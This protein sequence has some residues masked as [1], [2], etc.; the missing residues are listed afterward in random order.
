MCLRTRPK[1]VSAFIKD[2]FRFFLNLIVINWGYTY[3]KGDFIMNKYILLVATFLSGL[4]WAQTQPQ[5][6]RAAAV[7][8]R[9]NQYPKAPL[10][11][12]GYLAQN[13]NKC[14][15][16]VASQI[17]TL[18]EKNNKT[19]A[20]YNKAIGAQLVKMDGRC[21]YFRFELIDYTEDMSNGSYTSD[22]R[23]TYRCY[24]TADIK[25]PSQRVSQLPVVKI[26]PISLYED[27]GDKNYDDDLIKEKCD[28]LAISKKLHANGIDYIKSGKNGSVENQSTVSSSKKSQSTKS[29][30]VNTNN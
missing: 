20:A 7:N 24:E 13:K 11:L 12:D 29:K 25:L 22:F 4:I 1:N 8:Q 5:Q 10:S 27:L 2:N 30:K 18:T 3:L 15:N 21:K 23:F 9:N 19:W 28:V 16:H 26:N 14:M 17:K 6:I